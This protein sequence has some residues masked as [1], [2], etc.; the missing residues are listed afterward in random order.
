MKQTRLIF[1]DG[2]CFD[3]V[4]S[5]VK[6]GTMSNLGKLIN[7]CAA[8][9]ITSSLP[10]VS[11]VCWIIIFTGVDPGKHGFFGFGEH[12]SDTY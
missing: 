11:P 1:L 7:F 8:W 4:V 12:R 9:N 2:I 5:L 10:E 3:L 6:C